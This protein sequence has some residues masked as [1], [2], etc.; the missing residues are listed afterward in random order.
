MENNNCSHDK[1]PSLHCH[2]C[3]VEM[4]QAIIQSMRKEAYVISNRLDGQ[5][6]MHSPEFLRET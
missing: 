5:L 2:E 3:E 4:K 1:G 6:D